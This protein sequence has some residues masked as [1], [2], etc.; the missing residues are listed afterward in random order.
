VG[1]ASTE[2]NPF[3]PEC[4]HAIFAVSLVLEVSERAQFLFNS[5]ETPRGQ[6]Y[7]VDLPDPWAILLELL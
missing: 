2:E 1:I 4:V 7:K 5:A 3:E 6:V